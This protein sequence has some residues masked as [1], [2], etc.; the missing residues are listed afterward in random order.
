MF[1]Q[2]IFYSILHFTTIFQIS[3]EIYNFKS[4]NPQCTVL[5]SFLFFESVKTS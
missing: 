1:E 2:Q 4:D 3:R 5:I